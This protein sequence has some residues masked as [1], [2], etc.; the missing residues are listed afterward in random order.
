[1]LKSEI[2]IKARAGTAKLDFRAALRSGS[3]CWNL[4]NDVKGNSYVADEHLIFSQKKSF[5]TLLCQKIPIAC[6]GHVGAL[7]H[8]KIVESSCIVRALYMEG[9]LASLSSVCGSQILAIRQQS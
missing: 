7:R 2:D 9:S 1:M 8:V 5:L 6:P 3:K 4:G